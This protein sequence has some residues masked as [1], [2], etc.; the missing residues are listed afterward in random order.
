M[1]DG[2]NI[3]DEQN[4]VNDDTFYGMNKAQLAK[5]DKIEGI[6]SYLL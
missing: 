5:E 1:E 2:K 3:R 4:P 6:I